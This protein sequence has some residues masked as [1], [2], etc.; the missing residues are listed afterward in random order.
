MDGVKVMNNE[1]LDNDVIPCVQFLN[2]LNGIKTISS[3]SGHGKATGMIGFQCTNWE[4]LERIMIAV[5]SNKF[6]DIHWGTNFIHISWIINMHGAPFQCVRTKY[7]WDSLLHSLRVVCKDMTL[8][9]RESLALELAHNR[10]SR[11]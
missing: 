5:T 4:S 1:T 2:S 9:D 7:R 6:W 11:D 3:C 8:V 10:V